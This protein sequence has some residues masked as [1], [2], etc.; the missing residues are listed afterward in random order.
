[1]RVQILDVSG[2]VVG[3]VREATLEP[4]YHDVPI[5]ACRRDGR[6]LA[7]GVYFY[8]IEAPEGNEQGD[9]SS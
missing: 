5:R 7:S 2:R 3:T 4:G 9:S 1:V 8:T 6:R